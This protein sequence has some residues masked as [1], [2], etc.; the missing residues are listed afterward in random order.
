MCTSTPKVPKATTP[1]TPMPTEADAEAIAKRETLER[2]KRVNLYGRP[3]TIL[4]PMKRPSLLGSAPT[5]TKP[6][7]G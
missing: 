4:T 1:A 5:T 3:S 7:G 6:L 2:Q